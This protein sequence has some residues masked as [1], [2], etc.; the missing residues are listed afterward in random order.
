M[1]YEDVSEGFDASAFKSERSFRID[2]VSLRAVT[3]G[4]RDDGDSPQGPE[5]IEERRQTG[6][7]EAVVVCDQEI[8]RR[9]DL[10]C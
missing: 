9:N 5:C 3:C 2:R 6:S 1:Q 4:W 7:V 10:E 8:H